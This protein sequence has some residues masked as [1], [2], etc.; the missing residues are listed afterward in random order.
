MYSAEPIAMASRIRVVPA[1]PCFADRPNGE[2]VKHGDEAELE[3][4]LQREEE[5]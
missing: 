3:I 1:V 2:S 4:W 5:T